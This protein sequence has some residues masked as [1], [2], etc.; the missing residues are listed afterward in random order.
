[1][2]EIW[3]KHVEKI[4]AI[5]G[6]LRK[7]VLWVQLALDTRPKIRD[8]YTSWNPGQ[9]FQ[10]TVH[11]SSRNEITLLKNP[12]P[13]KVDHPAIPRC[14]L[15]SVLTP[16]KVGFGSHCRNLVLLDKAAWTRTTPEILD[17]REQNPS[18]HQYTKNSMTLKFTSRDNQRHR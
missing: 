16:F 4:E 13:S 6:Q 12:L 10:Q 7:R 3:H 5:L 1:M 2:K 11:S 14:V 15:P 18:N 9:W 8:T 17:G